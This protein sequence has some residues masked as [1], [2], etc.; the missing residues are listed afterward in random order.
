MQKW[1]ITLLRGGVYTLRDRLS[2]ID[3]LS[4]GLTPHGLNYYYTGT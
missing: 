1:Y 2:G 4:L 3:T